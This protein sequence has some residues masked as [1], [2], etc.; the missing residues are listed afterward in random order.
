MPPDIPD[1]VSP[2]RAI[3][4]DWDNTLVDNWQVILAALNTALVAMDQR[5]W[6]LSESRERIIMKDL[7]AYIA[8]SIL[9][10]DTFEKAAKEAEEKKRLKEI[11][12]RKKAEEK[13]KKDTQAQSNEA[14]SADPSK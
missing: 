3:L 1:P 6:T 14:E 10:Y 2:P 8:E 7:S 9:G 5:P 11:E 4:F 12:K 13:K